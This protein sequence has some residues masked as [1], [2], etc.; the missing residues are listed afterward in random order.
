MFLRN[1]GFLMRHDQD[2]KERRE[3]SNTI[4]IMNAWF[5]FKIFHASM[6]WASV[7]PYVTE[8]WAEINGVALV[9]I[10]FS[11]VS[12]GAEFSCFITGRIT[13]RTVP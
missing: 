10:I 3:I 11:L 4:C 5:V 13:R 7:V 9:A 12:N 1:L 8:S 6:S 2:S